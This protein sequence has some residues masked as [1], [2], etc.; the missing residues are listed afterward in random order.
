MAADPRLRD[1]EC[2]AESGCRYPADFREHREDDGTYAAD[3][4][5][6]L[7]S[8]GGMGVSR[9][10]CPRAFSVA[11]YRRAST[12]DARRSPTRVNTRCRR[13][14]TAEERLCAVPLRVTPRSRHRSS[15]FRGGQPH[16]RPRAAFR[17]RDAPPSRRARCGPRGLPE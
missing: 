8:A 6:E 3:A 13:A 15:A 7:D 4:L 14:R 17:T 10:R 11:P 16:V 1:A 12:R 2:A 9:R 5:D